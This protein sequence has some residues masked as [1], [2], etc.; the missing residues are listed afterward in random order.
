M[1]VKHLF[2]RGELCDFLSPTRPLGVQ[3]A[4]RLM[5]HTRA[6]KQS[7]RAGHARPSFN[8]PRRAVG[9]CTFLQTLTRCGD[10]A[11]PGL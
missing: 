5:P 1:I 10:K 9:S 2:G 7:R 3:H 4:G 8:G 11:Y 6:N